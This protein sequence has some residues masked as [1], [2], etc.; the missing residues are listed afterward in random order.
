MSCRGYTAS[1]FSQAFCTYQ[2]QGQPTP[3]RAEVR[4]DGDFQMLNDKFPKVPIPGDNFR[5]TNPL[6]IIPE[7]GKAS[8]VWPDR[9]FYHGAYQLEVISACLKKGLDR[10]A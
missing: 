10:L 1:T 6:L 3:S 7:I 5:I 4:N 2:C 8:L 9:F